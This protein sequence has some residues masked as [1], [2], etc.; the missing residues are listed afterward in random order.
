MSMVELVREENIEKND[1]IVKAKHKKKSNGEGLLLNIL[2]I[3][4]DASLIFLVYCIISLTLIA[5]IRVQGNSMYPTLHSGDFGL[6]NVIGY[7]LGGVNR[8]DIVVAYSEEEGIYIIKRVIGLPGETVQVSDNV[9]Y[10]DGM[11]YDEEFLNE[12]YQISKSMEINDSFTGN[13]G[14]Y[15][16]GEDEYFVMGDNRPVSK[17]SRKFG[18]IKKSSIRSKGIYVI[19]PWNKE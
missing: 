1:E 6:S 10:I 12:D 8:F 11:R 4:R 18:A 2:V 9:L 7:R 5:P 16:I 19:Y 14:P 3:L 15:T 17:D 13:F